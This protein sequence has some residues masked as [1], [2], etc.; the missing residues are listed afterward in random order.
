M[1]FRSF[2]IEQNGKFNGQN[3]LALRLIENEINNNLEFSE[4]ILAD[5]I[6]YLA[7][8]Y[9]LLIETESV[10]D[11]I[12]LE[13]GENDQNGNGKNNNDKEPILLDG[14]DFEEDVVCGLK[15]VDREPRNILRT[16]TFSNDSVHNFFKVSVPEYDPFSGMFVD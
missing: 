5:Q 2:A 12:K 3:K 8:L 4:N 1:L 14:K 10:L 9:D 13:S 16:K 11:T 7:I 15:V 6:Y